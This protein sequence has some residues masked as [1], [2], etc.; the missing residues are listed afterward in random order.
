MILLLTLASVLVM[1]IVLTCLCTELA[2]EATTVVVVAVDITVLV[3]PGVKAVVDKSAHPALTCTDVAP[4]VT[5]RIIELVDVN[6]IVK[7]L[8]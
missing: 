1:R 4:V 3:L 2:G 7:T 6:N 5:I 8:C